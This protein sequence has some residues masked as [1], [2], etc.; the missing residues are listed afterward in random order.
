MIGNVNMCL[1]RFFN[2]I[3]YI[4]LDLEFFLFMEELVLWV[5]GGIFIL[6]VMLF[7][8]LVF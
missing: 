6:E 4:K 1:G 5:G 7:R 8:F 2:Y 3:I